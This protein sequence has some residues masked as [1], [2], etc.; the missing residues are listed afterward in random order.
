MHQVRQNEGLFCLLR[1]LHLT[2]RSL[3]VENCLAGSSFD[4][5]SN[6]TLRYR[7]HPSCAIYT[8]Q[9]QLRL[10]SS[11]RISI[12]AIC[13]LKVKVTGTLTPFFAVRT[14]FPDFSFLSEDKRGT[15]DD[16]CHCSPTY[17]KWFCISSL[18]M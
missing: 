1:V 11:N 3:L 15:C 2:S 4:H 14:G 17:A 8:I 6:L 9:I 7:A 5:D 13:Q 18:S 12:A 10:I 16:I